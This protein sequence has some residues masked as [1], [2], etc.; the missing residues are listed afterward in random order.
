MQPAR[1]HVLIGQ[2]RHDI[3]RP[4]DWGYPIRGIVKNDLLY[5]HNF[6]PTRWPA[7]NPETGYLNCDGS[8]TKTH[9]LASPHRTASSNAFGSSA[10]ASGPPKSSTI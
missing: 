9:I 6:E 10:S 2:E 5:L 3:G 8:P 1:D 4:H 7:C